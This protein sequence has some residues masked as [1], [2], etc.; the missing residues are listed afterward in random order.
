MNKLLIL[1]LILCSLFSFSQ[2]K[3]T[4]PTYSGTPSTGDTVIFTGGQWTLAPGGGGTPSS[5]PL[6]LQYNNGGTFGG[7][8]NSSWN[9]TNLFTPPIIPGTIPC[10]D[11]TVVQNKLAKL[12]TSTG[13]L[14]LAGTSDIIVP[15]CVIGSVIDSSHALCAFG[16][17][18]LLQMDG[19][20]VAGHYIIVS[21]TSAGKGHDSG[22]AAGS[23][24]PAG[25]TIIGQVTAAHSGAGLYTVK[26]MAAPYVVQSNPASACPTVGTICKNIGGVL[27]DSHVDEVTNSGKITNLWEAV[28]PCGTSVNDLGT[29]YGD[30]A[31]KV[32]VTCGP[33]SWVLNIGGTP[34]FA[35]SIAGGILGNHFSSTYPIITQTIF[36]SGTALNT[37]GTG[38]LNF[39]GTTTAT[40]TFSGTYTSHPE[41]TL[42]PQFDT[43]GA[44]YWVTYTA[45]TAFTVNFSGAV[46]GD[47][48][49]HCDAR[50]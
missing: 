45:A 22:I 19:T 27:A 30:I 34:V 36:G 21:T 33:G 24:P 11:G 23:A 46:T 2:T 10:S 16:G 35:A 5:P 8:P 7:I 37:D 47:V 13:C 9:G 12:S 1:L 39:S 31:N 17:D 50:N 41:C 40:Y 20:T 38:E 28:F 44:R 18:V 14:S 42:T 43:A 29:W 15:V 32:G 25:I 48:S 6:S 3:R 4:A 49:Y 26:Q